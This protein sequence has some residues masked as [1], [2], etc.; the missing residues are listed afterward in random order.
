MKRPSIRKRCQDSFLGLII[1]SLVFA[2]PLCPR[3]C[4]RLLINLTVFLSRF[5][6]P[7]LLR[8][9]EA[10]LVIAFPDLPASR[11]RHLARLNL[12]N[13]LWNGIE[14]VYL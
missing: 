1:S 5:L 13:L 12:R 4:L 3:P 11:R 9:I 8:L 7:G 6:Y 2:L 14:V 10:N